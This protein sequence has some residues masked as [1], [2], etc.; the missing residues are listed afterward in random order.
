MKLSGQ[1]LI[2]PTRNNNSVVEVLSDDIIP[3]NENL[4]GK[5]LM[6]DD[7]YKRYEEGETRIGPNH[8]IKHHSFKPKSLVVGR[9]TKALTSDIVIRARMKMCN[10]GMR[11]EQTDENRY[12]SKVP[13]L[14]PTHQWL[15]NTDPTAAINRTALRNIELVQS[16][17][18]NNLALE[19]QVHCF[20]ED[21]YE[22]AHKNR[23]GTATFE[24]SCRNY[25]G[26]ELS[27]I[28]I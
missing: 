12:V 15:K 26:P 10:Q 23:R 13:R 14:N 21:I 19:K 24:S 16:I 1:D 4:A 20:P 27:L 6:L 11:A 2:Q 3:Y 22:S 5:P 18:L 25:V 17:K 9:L 8:V 7:D 28:H